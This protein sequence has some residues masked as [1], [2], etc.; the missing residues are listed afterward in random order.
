ML[1]FNL[2]IYIFTMYFINFLTKNIFDFDFI[3]ILKQEVNKIYR[4]L[5]K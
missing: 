4:N 5:K 2:I 1:L 3:D